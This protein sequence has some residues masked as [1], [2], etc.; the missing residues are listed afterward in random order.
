[1]KNLSDLA[2]KYN[3]RLWTIRAMKFEIPTTVLLTTYFTACGFAY[4][5]GFWYRTEV[6]ISI[7]L[8]LLTVTEIVK[9]AALSFI[10]FLGAAFATIF[11]SVVTYTDYKKDTFKEVSENPKKYLF[12][13]F[14]MMSTPII[15]IGGVYYITW[16]LNAHDYFYI[17][18][19][20]GF[21]GAAI[22]FSAIFYKEYILQ[23]VNA[24]IRFFVLALL[25]FTPPT[26]FLL[27]G[28][29]YLQGSIQSKP[30]YIINTEKCSPNKS[31][32]FRLL[33]I[34]GSKGIAI[35]NRNQSVCIFNDSEQSYSQ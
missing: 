15:F 34:Y 13:P 30:L 18:N 22:L 6:D 20:M 28:K 9:A 10:I 5:W 3:K 29:S 8:Q 27:G 1:M 21:A 19:S 11:G 12:T 33:A 32:K 24:F 26:L 23:N 7:I 25:F 4:I 31:E 2:N 17:A 16:A 14:F 35:S